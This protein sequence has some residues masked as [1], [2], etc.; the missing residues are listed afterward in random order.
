MIGLADERIMLHCSRPPATSY[1]PYCAS[2]CFLVLSIP[3]LS[4]FDGV[5]AES[6]QPLGRCFDQLHIT[7]LTRFHYLD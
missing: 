5:F 4:S 2:E 1:A 6:A 7:P 3:I